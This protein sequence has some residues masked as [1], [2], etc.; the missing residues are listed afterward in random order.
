M[1]YAQERA[2]IETRFK[3]R[4]TAVLPAVALGYDGHPFE[5]AQGSQSARLT[6]LDGEGINQTIGAPG[7]NIVRHTGV[8][9]IQLFV[10][11]G[12]GSAALRALLD[13]IEPIF[14]NWRSGHLLF[15]AM[16][17]QGRR[18]EAPFLTANAVFPFQRDKA[19]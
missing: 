12:S 3:D 7:Q 14:T 15:R 19:I 6:I 9:M 18:E 17:V 16:S 11:G 8:V 13:G 4:M 1:S 10:P 5:P 2:D